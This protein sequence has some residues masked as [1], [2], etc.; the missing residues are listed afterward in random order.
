MQAHQRPLPRLERLA[1]PGGL[2]GLE[3]RE[4]VVPAG[5]LHVLTD[6]AGDLQEDAGRA[7][8]L[9]EL[10]GGVQVLRSPAEGHR[11]PRTP[12]Q[13]VAQA[14]ERLG[15][16]GVEVGQHGQVTVLGV[17]LGAFGGDDEG[18]WTFLP[19]FVRDRDDGCLGDLGDRRQCLLER[20]RADPLTAA[21]DQ[22]FG[23]ILNKDVTFFIDS[24]DIAG[25]EPAV[26]EAFGASF[27]IPVVGSG[28][29]GP[30]E[31]ELA[32]LLAV[33]LH[34]SPVL[35]DNLHLDTGHHQPL[36]ALL[37]V[38]AIGVPFVHVAF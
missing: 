10:A 30:P 5:D 7:A 28:N 6:G 18:Q 17:Q 31:A 20:Q 2:R 25:M 13:L 22:V 9:V 4:G 24:D 21:L 35:I 8:A 11:P 1:V 23:P 15:G 29:P 16:A 19:A 3:A 27:G 38:A 14:A 26:L 32:H 33:P 12:G 34:C 36:F 37:G